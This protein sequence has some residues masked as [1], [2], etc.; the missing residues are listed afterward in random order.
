MRRMT[1]LAMAIALAAAGCTG[2]GTSDNP[3]GG[4]IDSVIVGADEAGNPT[5]DF[6]PGLS[7]SKVQTEVLW[8][9]EGERLAA[10]D[11]IL[12]DMY[13]VSLD[14]DRVLK[15][16]YSDLPE[17]FLLAPELVGD[18][19][20]NQ[21]IDQRVGARLLFVSPPAEGHED[22]G[23]VA[24]LV[25]VLPARATGD[26]AGS[27]GDIPVVLLAP[28]GEPTITIRDTDVAP[29]TLTTVTLI[30]G[31]GPQVLAGS[32]ILVNYVGV[33][34][35]DGTIYKSSWEDGAGPWATRIGYGEV[36][37]GWDQGLID[38][39]EGSQVLLLIPPALAYGDEAMAFVVDILA[40]WNPE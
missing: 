39:A 27:R 34:Y 8:E 10:G 17:A 23:A 26:H 37:A 25:D 5:F 31:T 40:V 14:N 33:T 22:T 6:T 29:A 24:L 30:Q 3:S 4:T 20:Y 16:T 2:S 1:A 21:L 9:G 38:R 18:D 36:P 7:Y 28:D 19:L 15:D 11:R 12:L 35:P 32:R 13:A